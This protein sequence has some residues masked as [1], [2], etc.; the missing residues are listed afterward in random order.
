MQIGLFTPVFGKLS[1]P[2]L[3]RELKRYPTIQSLELGTGG[4]PGSSHVE[5]DALLASAERRT[6]FQQ[7]L[8]DAGLSLS[9]LS[10]HNNPIHPDPEKAQHDDATLRKTIQL[11]ELLGVRTVVTFSG[12]PGGSTADRTPNWITA[13]WPPE[14]ADA[15]QWQWAERLIPYWRQLDTLAANAGVRVALEAHPG[16]CVYNAET[17]LTLR[18]E[19]GTSIGINLDPSHMWW[20][21]A[22]IPTVIAALGEAIFHFHAKDVALNPANTARNGVL[23]TKSYAHMAERSW[24]FRSVG[25]GHGESEWKAIVGALRLAGYDGV[26]SIE[27]EDAL[28][29]IHEGLSAA[30]A[31]LSR[32]VV[33][34]PPVEPWW[35]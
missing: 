11:A 2:E 17:L 18:A 6:E 31:M 13:A 14:F 24:L 15:L 20:Q 33:R 9:A 8:A 1:F 32:V 29:S 7:Q 27:H 21:G 19:A 35:L 5:V 4:W 25:W 30:V 10:C 16:F 12:C 34:E 3:L 22:D 28:L 26:L 23:D